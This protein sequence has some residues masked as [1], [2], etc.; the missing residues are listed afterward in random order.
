MDLA[1]AEAWK[2]QGVTY[3]NPAVGSVIIDKNGK[4]V[5]ISAHRKAGEPH[6]EVMAI[7]DAYVEI[8]GDRTIAESVDS[9]Y[10]HNYLYENHKDIF[11]GSTIFV[12]LEP[13]NHW[14]KTPPCSIIIEKLGF[15]KV[16]IGVGEENPKATGG[17][18]FL[19]NNGIEVSFC[20]D[21][22]RESSLK[23]IEPFRLWSSK[24][25]V[26]F[27]FAQ[28]LNGNV[29]DG[30]IS[31][32]TSREFVHKIR[33]NIDLLV[34]GGNTVRTDRP[35][36]DS[37]L[38]GGKAPDVL[39]YSKQND[40]DRTIPLF[41]VPDREVIIS[42]DL[43]ILD[44][45]NY[46]MIEGGK[47]MLQEFKNRVDYLLLFVSP[48]INGLSNIQLLGDPNFEFLYQRKI[49]DDLLIWLHKVA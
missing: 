28:T 1:I 44:N 14:G 42:D 18:K 35:T 25:F 49:G 46:I 9:N 23:L 15:K 12:T 38:T 41:S 29:T 21:E 31:S 40:F 39:I 19:Q 27:K 36:L 8:T 2:Y 11:S 24:K 10:L 17:A 13:C 47:S 4:I 37:R 5:S 43:S 30:V 48:T 7:R 32:Q 33:E 20:S 16:V 26:F 6:S 34:I 45:Y 3:P 22:C